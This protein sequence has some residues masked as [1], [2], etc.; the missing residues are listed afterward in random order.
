[1]KSP[2]TIHCKPGGTKCGR[3]RAPQPKRLPSS[4]GMGLAAKALRARRHGTCV[5]H[6]P[7]QGFARRS[8]RQNRREGDGNSGQTRAVPLRPLP[9]WATGCRMTCASSER[10]VPAQ[11]SVGTCWRLTTSASTSRN[12]NSGWFAWLSSR[13]PGQLLLGNLPANLTRRMRR[14]MNVDVRIAGAHLGKEVV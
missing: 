3:F 8:G 14:R 9:A 12:D 4:T 10:R 1:M 13:V 7:P 2:L 6:E 5:H 11:V